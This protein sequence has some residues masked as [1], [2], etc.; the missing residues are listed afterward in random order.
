MPKMQ[1]YSLPILTSMLQVI[2]FGIRYNV[3]IVSTFPFEDPSAPLN[4]N[5]TFL[6][7]NALDLDLPDPPSLNPNPNSNPNPSVSPTI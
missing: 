1:I 7:Y 4:P 2:I 3:L 6:D 5:L